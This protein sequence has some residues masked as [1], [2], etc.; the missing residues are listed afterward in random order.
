M[1]ER[2]DLGT[3]NA[4]VDGGVPNVECL[5]LALQNRSM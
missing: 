2:L 4:E 3:G 5:R 1:R